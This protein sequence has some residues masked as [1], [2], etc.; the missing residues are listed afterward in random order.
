MSSHFT[1]EPTP[2]W[3]LSL[4]QLSPSLLLLLLLLST[5]LLWPC[6]LL[7]I[8]LYLVVVNKCYSEAPK[9]CCCCCCCCC[10][11]YCY[12]YCYCYHYCC[13]WCW[14]CFHVQPNHCVKVV[15][16]CVVVGVVTIVPNLL[17]FWPKVFAATPF[18]DWVTSLA[19]GI[20]KRQ[21]QVIFPCP[22]GN[23]APLGVT[24]CIKLS[25]VPSKVAFYQTKSASKVVYHWR[26][27]SIEG[28]LQPQV[29]LWWYQMYTL[30]VPT[31]QTSLEAN[32]DRRKKTLLGAQASTLS[33]I[34]D[35]HKDWFGR[36]LK[37]YYFCHLL[38]MHEN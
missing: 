13:C 10:Y 28:H 16:H 3:Q 29:V 24:Y 33:K 34:R 32:S 37:A 12:F 36:Y 15:L 11:S 14:C 8:T 30:H 18:F 5:L 17:R 21:A 31:L 38:K 6:L 26:S 25:S 9:G 2:S 19:E 27:S 23:P 20:T 1:V 4:A 35:L 22:T 7:L